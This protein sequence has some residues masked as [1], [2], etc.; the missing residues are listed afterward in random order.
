MFVIYILLAV[1]VLIFLLS[2]VMPKSY[3]IEKSAVIRKPKDVV[4]ENVG[5]FNNYAA[6]NPWQKMEP[7]ATR[8]ITGTP[9]SKGHKYE[10]IGKKI[11]QG[12]LTVT[13]VDSNHINLDLQFIKPWKATAKDNW[14]F[15]PWG[16]GSETKVT[17]QNSGDLPWP[18]ARLMSPLIN[19]NLNQQFTIGMENLKKMC[20]G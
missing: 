4:M 13:N 9:N 3:S 6:W 15:E 10:W 17:W 14:L 8:N 19:K 1:I 12:N 5:N 2:F 18:M 20:E 11:G 16:D 7:S